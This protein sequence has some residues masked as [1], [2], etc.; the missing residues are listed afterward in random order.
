MWRIIEEMQKKVRKY[1]TN[2]IFLVLTL[3][4]MLVIF[5]YSA[6]TAEESEGQSMAVGMRVGSILHADFETWSEEAKLE[7]AQIYDKPIRKFA[8]MAEYAV[9]G[10]LLVGVVVP[11]SESK[12]K[13][14]FIAWLI[15][16]VY[17]CT[18]EVHQLLVPGRYG[19]IIDVGIDAIGAAIGVGVAKVFVNWIEKRQEKS[20]GNI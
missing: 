14:L 1:K 8:H 3:L 12:K 17:A 18:D 5:L 16:V 13:I 6:K 4:W 9:L 7:F 20:S 15:A 19:S 10:L 11:G 2:I